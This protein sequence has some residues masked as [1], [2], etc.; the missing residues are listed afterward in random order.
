MR[1]TKLQLL[2]SEVQ[3]K[4]FRM[5]AGF[6]HA[7]EFGASHG[8]P[9]RRVSVVVWSLLRFASPTRPMRP[10]PRVSPGTPQ[11]VRAQRKG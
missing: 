10:S 5:G 3:S 4:E 1:V 8:R 7:L 9:P 6:Q 11:E 2:K